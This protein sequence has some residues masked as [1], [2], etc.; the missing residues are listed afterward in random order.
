MKKIKYSLLPLA[1]LI[2]SALLPAQSQA[3]APIPFN[4]KIDH[5]IQERAALRE[6]LS[7]FYQ[8]EDEAPQQT[9]QSEKDRE[10]VKAF[11]KIELGWGNAPEVALEPIKSEENLQEPQTKDSQHILDEIFQD[12]EPSSLKAQL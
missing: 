10:R 12:R 5:S 11:L 2:L 7:Q 9:E 8:S 1:G 3:S 4:S 6:S